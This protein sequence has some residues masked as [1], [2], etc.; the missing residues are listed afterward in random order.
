[1]AKLFLGLGANLGDGEET[2]RLAIS[3][4]ENDLGEVVAQSSFYRTK[5]WGFV[6]AH[7]F[8]NACICVETNCSPM[9]CLQ[10][11][12]KIEKDL[13]R[14]EKTV[15]TYADR[16]IDIDLL[17]YDDKII[18]EP[19]LTIPHPLLHR[20]AF[21]LDPLCEIAADW[22]HPLLHQSIRKLKETLL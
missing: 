22:Q 6:S 16:E 4:I 15:Q 9:D 3:A 18:Q 19:T 12:Q 8:V 2:L 17:F 7:D 20:R 13:G 14:K 21:V 11:T 1:M 5:P 10:L